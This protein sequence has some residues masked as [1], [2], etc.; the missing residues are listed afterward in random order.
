MSISFLLLD[1]SFE[2]RQEE[3]LLVK[4]NELNIFRSEDKLQSGI[5]PNTFHYNSEDEIYYLNYGIEKP[6]HTKELDKV[7]ETVIYH[8]YNKIMEIPIAVLNNQLVIVGR[9]YER[10]NKNLKE[11]LKNFIE[12][13]IIKGYILDQLEL[14][15]NFIRFLENSHELRRLSVLPSQTGNRPIEDLGAK[16]KDDIK[17]TEFYDETQDD[18]RNNIQI[19]IRNRWISLDRRG[20]IS[21]PRNLEPLEILSILNKISERITIFGITRGRNQ[22]GNY[23]ITRYL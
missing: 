10:L 13:N 8:D 3:E 7:N 6:Q 11:R 18:L 2:K 21:L 22:N 5:I 19:S 4:V 20:I 12:K 23:N 14:E 16:A 17:D 9:I 1:G 15:D